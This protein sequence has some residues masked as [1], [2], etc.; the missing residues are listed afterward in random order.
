MRPP[1]PGV[2]PPGPAGPTGSSHLLGPLGTG[3]PEFAAGVNPYQLLLSAQN[4]PVAK[5][6]AELSPSFPC[7]PDGNK[8]G[9]NG[10]GSQKLS[11]LFQPFSPSGNGEAKAK[12]E[13]K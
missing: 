7:S 4:P 11:P 13:G 2:F 9:S 3:S 10:F 5:G 12:D 8:S 1:F 6:T